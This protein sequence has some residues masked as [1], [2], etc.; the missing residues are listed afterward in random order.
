MLTRSINY[1]PLRLYK[2][3]LTRAHDCETGLF[4]ESDVESSGSFI[5]LDTGGIL[6]IKAGYAWDGPSGPTVDTPNFM[7]GSLVHDAL[8]QLIREGQLDSSYREMS[9]KLLRH[10]C[11]EDGMSALRAGYVY[12]SV[13]LFG[14]TAAKRE[15]PPVERTAP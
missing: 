1:R 8:Y 12:R 11:R 13:R 5:T 15:H 10:L 6:R 9:D 14:G 3:Q 2:Y 4:V 7:R